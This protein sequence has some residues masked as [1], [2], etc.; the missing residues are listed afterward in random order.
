MNATTRGRLLICDNEIPQMKALCATLE[1][2]GCSPTGYSSARQAL[3]T[4][5]SG[6][7]DVLLTDLQMPEMDG[8]ALFEAVH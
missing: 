4:L 1:L 6:E 3:A 7:V 8:I 5:R 2:E